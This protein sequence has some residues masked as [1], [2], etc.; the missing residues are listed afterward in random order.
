M[1]AENDQMDIWLIHN[2][3]LSSWDWMHPDRPDANKGVPSKCK[4]EEFYFIFLLFI[5]V[6]AVMI[7]KKKCLVAMQSLLYICWAPTTDEMHLLI[8][9]L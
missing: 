6:F 4:P 9:T 1:K 2:I 5:I 8:M 3:P 7:G